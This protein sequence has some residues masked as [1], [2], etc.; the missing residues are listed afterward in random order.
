MQ[1]CHLTPASLK[2]LLCIPS[3]K[4]RLQEQSAGTLPVS[5]T[6]PQYKRFVWAPTMHTFQKGTSAQDCLMSPAN[7]LYMHLQQKP[8]S[9]YMTLLV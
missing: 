7:F 9:I 4:I 2:I 6:P 8:N 3:W 5:S 1:H